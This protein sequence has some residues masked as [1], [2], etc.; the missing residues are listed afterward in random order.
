MHFCPS[1]L[2]TNRGQRHDV[3]TENF[4]IDRQR[5][6]GRQHQQQNRTRAIVIRR[7]G[8]TTSLARGL[9]SLGRSAL[10]GRAR[11]ESRSR[12]M[13]G[14]LTITMPAARS[15]LAEAQAAAGISS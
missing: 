15:E 14:S 6:K 2:K 1:E 5:G 8:L 9:V 3:A 13:D 7:R 4:Q 10:G 11:S 12:R